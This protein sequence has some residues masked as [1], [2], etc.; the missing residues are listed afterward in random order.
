[1]LTTEEQIKAEQQS[2]PNMRARS[3]NMRVCNA[4][5]R[6][7]GAPA[8]VNRGHAPVRRPVDGRVRDI[9]AGREPVDRARPQC[10]QCAPPLYPC[11]SP[12]PGPVKT[13]IVWVQ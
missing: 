11:G 2:S 1:M 13:Y 3:P 5:R 8:L 12:L 4:G 10:L 7:K 9:P 6:A